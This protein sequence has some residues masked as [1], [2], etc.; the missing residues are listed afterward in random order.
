MLLF[1]DESGTDRKQAPYEV[2]AGVTIHESRFWNLVQA[3]RAAELELFGVRLHQLGIEFKGKALLK[4]KIFRFANQGPEIEIPRRRE[5]TRKFLEKG[6]S[7]NVMLS[8]K[9]PRRE[10]FTAYGQS[11]LEFVHRIFDLCATHQVRIFASIVSKNA[12]IP[13]GDL[14]RKDYAYLFERYF[15]Y[16][17]DTAPNEHGL[18]IFDEIEKS[19]CRRLINQMEKYFVETSKG[20]I[21]SARIIPEPFFVHS[22]LTKAVQITDIVAYCLNWGIRLKRMTEPTRLEMEPFGQRALD[23]KYVGKRFDDDGNEWPVY[24]VTYIDDL[25]PAAG[26]I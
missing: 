16:L 8:S 2:L 26:R 21:R 9:S 14:L 7:K 1:I 6:F 25:R 19:R 4:R 24:G 12:P 10:E 22:D 13:I 11:V 15:Y 18:I 23:L 5:L 20:R 17:E 3:I